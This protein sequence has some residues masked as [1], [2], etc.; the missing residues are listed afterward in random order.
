MSTLKLLPKQD[1]QSWMDTKE[2]MDMDMYIKEDM[3]IMEEEDMVTPKQQTS[4]CIHHF[5]FTN[6]K[7]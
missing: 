1:L 5:L 6:F 4:N 3:N 2:A 7:L